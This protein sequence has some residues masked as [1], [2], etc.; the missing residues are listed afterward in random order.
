MT[1][2]KPSGIETPETNSLTRRTTLD[3][4]ELYERALKMIANV[5]IVIG[6]RSAHPQEKLNWVQEFAREALNGIDPTTGKP[7]SG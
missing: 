4:C 6:D 7:A 2:P 1:S 5:S 3:K